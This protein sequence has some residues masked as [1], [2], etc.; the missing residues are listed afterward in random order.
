MT[1]LDNLNAFLTHIDAALFKHINSGWPSP[2]LD[3]I[4]AFATMFGVGVVQAGL[5]LVF[6][7]LGLLMDRVNL[8]RAGYAGLI[9]FAAAGTA[10]QI[11]KF[12]WGRPRPLLALFDVRIMDTPRFTHSFPSGH[13]M[14]AFAVAVACSAFLPKLRYVLIPLAFATAVSRVY[15]GVHY[16]LDAAYGALV[17]VL[18]GILCARQVCPHEPSPEPSNEVTQQDC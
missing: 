7:A 8:R 13:T 11:A 3:H 16:P 18:V 9:A 17:G 14:T 2:A 1:V 4:M 12:V 10:V 6:I 15:I 5:S